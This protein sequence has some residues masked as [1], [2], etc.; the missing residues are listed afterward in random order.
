VNDANFKQ[1]EQNWRQMDPREFKA[2]LK[3]DSQ[4]L[5]TALVV[6]LPKIYDNPAMAQDPKIEEVKLEVNFPLPNNIQDNNIMAEPK[7]NPFNQQSPVK[8]E[9]PMEVKKVEAKEE[10]QMNIDELLEGLSQSIENVVN[11][12][13]QAA[14]QPINPASSLISKDNNNPAPIIGNAQPAEVTQSSLPPQNPPKPQTEAVFLNQAEEAKGFEQQVVA[15]PESQ[16]EE[17]PEKKEEYSPE[18]LAAFD[19]GQEAGAQLEKKRERL[20][21]DYD[22]TETELIQKR[23]QADMERR[24]ML[25]EKEIE[26]QKKK[27]EIQLNA[28]QELKDWIE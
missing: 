2:V 11:T 23:Q 14:T 10:K 8:Q 17:V 6:Q 21:S 16:N 18:K 24:A 5:V 28:E 13:P 26:E 27:K 20:P 9:N 4:N 12:N 25:Q 7:A 19:T 15:T 3:S 1:G 22:A